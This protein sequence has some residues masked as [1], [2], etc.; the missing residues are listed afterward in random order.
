MENRANAG[1]PSSSF[2]TVVRQIFALKCQLGSY[3]KV[4]ATCGFCFKTNRCST[5]LSRRENPAKASWQEADAD[6]LCARLGHVCRSHTPLSESSTWEHQKGLH[7][8]N[9]VQILGSQS[10]CETY[11]RLGGQRYQHAEFR[12]YRVVSCV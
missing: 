11:P 4:E 8:S 10:Q 6:I 7:S 1:N 2:M 5:L 3:L 9:T 12:P